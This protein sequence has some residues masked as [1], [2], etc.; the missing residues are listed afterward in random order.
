MEQRGGE[1]PKG[2]EG[3]K[4][5]SMW[6]DA[7]RTSWPCRSRE[8]VRC[9]IYDVGGRT[10]TLPRL[11]KY[12]PAQTP[13]RGFAAVSIKEKRLTFADTRRQWSE[14]QRRATAAGTSS[15]QYVAT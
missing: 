14:T 15:S 11:T 2:G 3:G 5:G 1:A 6:D 13:R 10:L 9:S 8:G 7:E 4:R 12:V